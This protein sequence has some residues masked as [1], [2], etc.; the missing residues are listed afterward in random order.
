MIH[1]LCFWSVRLL[2]VRSLNL[3]TLSAVCGSCFNSQIYYDHF[4]LQEMEFGVDGYQGKVSI[5]R[6]GEL[7][8]VAN[9]WWSWC[10]RLLI[11]CWRQL[12]SDIPTVTHGLKMDGVTMTELTRSCFFLLQTA[13]LKKCTWDA[14]TCIFFEPGD[15]KNNHFYGTMCVQWSVRIKHLST[16]CSL[17][18]FN[19]FTRHCTFNLN[20][21]FLG[22]S[23]RSRVVRDQVT[24]CH[25]WSFLAV[26]PSVSFKARHKM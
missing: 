4:Y 20:G 13:T 10:V 5:W 12:E 24:S 11:W 7:L 19:Y 22:H 9:E 2:S 15:L 21:L 18:Y 8:V 17:N 25:N 16:Y 6:L 14:V 3:T 26:S 23:H 1:K